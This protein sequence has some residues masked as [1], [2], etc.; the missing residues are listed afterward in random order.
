MGK[1]IVEYNLAIKKKKNDLLIHSIIYND[2][3]QN[4][5]CLGLGLDYGWHEESGGGI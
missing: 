2:R 1:Q 4:S 5:G 3:N